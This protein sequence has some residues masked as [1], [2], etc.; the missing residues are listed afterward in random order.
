MAENDGITDHRF[1]TLVDRA[2]K[3]GVE[4][5]FDGRI[6]Q[7]K[8]GQIELNVAQSVARFLCDPANT[9]AQVWTLE[10]PKMRLAV[11]GASKDLLAALEPGADDETPLEID[12]TVSNVIGERFEPS[13]I[14]TSQA[15]MR[16]QQRDQQGGA[17]SRVAVGTGA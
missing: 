8:P 13:T 9:Q 4:Y 14:Q 10:G 15:R 2:M 11:R 1:C 17:Q 5:M 12:T 16:A 6:Y 7:F 3:G